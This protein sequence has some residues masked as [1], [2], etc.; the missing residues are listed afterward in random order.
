[1]RIANSKRVKDALKKISYSDL[2]DW[3]ETREFVELKVGR[4]GDLV[5]YRV[6]DDGR[7]ITKR[8]YDEWWENFY[9]M[10]P[11]E[12]HDHEIE[13]TLNAIQK[14]FSKRHKRAVYDYAKH[15]T[16]L[17]K[18]RRV[19]TIYQEQNKKGK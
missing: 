12:I 11:L 19:Y 15:L 1:M 17:L 5:T 16:K 8:V 13:N 18:Q 4:W 7:I 2:Y 3:Y 10:K 14:A 9:K 6:Y